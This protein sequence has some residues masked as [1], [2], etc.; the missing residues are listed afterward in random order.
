MDWS[1]GELLAY[2]SRG[3]ELRPGDVLGSGTVPGGCLLEH[4]DTPDM[5]DYA[6]WLRPG[7]VVSLR[8]DGIGAT[9]QTVRPAP[10]MTPLRSGF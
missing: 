4:L 6:G 7:D 1:F 8:A 3:T 10:P 9:A 2:V 5:A